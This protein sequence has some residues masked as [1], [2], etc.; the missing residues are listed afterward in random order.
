[1]TTKF[2]KSF[3][4]MLI[5]WNDIK[6]YL[7]FEDLYFVPPPNSMTLVKG[8]AAHDDSGTWSPQQSWKH[9]H[10]QAITLHLF[11]EFCALIVEDF[12]GLFC[13]RSSGKWLH[14]MKQ[15]FIQA[16]T[17]LDIH[18]TLPYLRFFFQTLKA[19]RYHQIICRILT[20][21]SQQ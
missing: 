3:S 2:K 13:V 17:P 1:M 21:T 7:G 8:D 12:Q 14:L 19:H 18:M 15:L 6:I 4:P 11:C 10:K 16:T 5:C 9:G 20:L